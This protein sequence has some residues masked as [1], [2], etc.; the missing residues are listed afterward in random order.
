MPIPNHEAV[1]DLANL[2]EMVQD[3]G[4]QNGEALQILGLLGEVI[5]A[6]QLEIEELKAKVA[7]LDRQVFRA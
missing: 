2:R 3:G 5:E 7:K 1:A 4:I 6:Q